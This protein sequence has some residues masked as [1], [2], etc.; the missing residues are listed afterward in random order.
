MVD[1]RFFYKKEFQEMEKH[2]F[3]FSKARRATDQE[4]RLASYISNCV[5]QINFEVMYVVFSECGKIQVKESNP[6]AY[7][8]KLT[9]A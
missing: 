1:E 9:E 7:R 6:A 4:G 8:F 3:S 2:C 5:M